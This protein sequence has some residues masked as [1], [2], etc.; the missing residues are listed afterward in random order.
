MGVEEREQR[1]G[2]LYVL[3]GFERHT[4]PQG[5]DLSLLDLRGHRRGGKQPMHY[6]V[7]RQV[8][9]SGSK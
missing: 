7:L 1:L 8:I 9:L 3:V 6:P 5:L 2:I 4:T